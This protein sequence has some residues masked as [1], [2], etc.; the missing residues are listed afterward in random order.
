MANNY[1]NPGE[2]ITF[3]AGAD[4]ASGQAVVIGSLLGVSLTAVANGAT[5]EAA[6]EGVWGLPCASAA[7]I[8]RGAKLIWDVSA[9]E[10]ILTGAAEGDLVGCA[11]AV[12]AA[13]NGVTK[14]WAKLTPGT[15]T[16][17]AGGG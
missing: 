11:T 9:G 14:V 7:V 13:G 10:F 1:V 6:I 5:G 17:Q 2:H 8:T 3:T 4:V 15:A 12:A 16:I